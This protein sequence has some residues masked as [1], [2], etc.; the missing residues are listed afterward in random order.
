MY[1]PPQQH[2]AVMRSDTRRRWDV[3]ARAQRARRPAM[4]ALEASPAGGCSERP[5]RTS[6]EAKSRPLAHGAEQQSCTEKH[7]A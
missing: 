5:D 1:R 4:H 6:D 7:E 3:S 2:L